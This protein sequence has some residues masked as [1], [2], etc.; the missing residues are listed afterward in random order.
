VP[1]P[2]AKKPS[3]EHPR[4]PGV[5]RGSAARRAEPV[6]DMATP[7]GIAAGSNVPRSDDTRLNIADLVQRYHAELYRY[8]YRLSGSQADAEDLTQQV[9]L[10]AQVRGHQLRDE[11]H[12]R[13]WLFTI[14]RNTYLKMVR[15][16]SP[17]SAASLDLDLNGVPA[18]MAE[19]PVDRERLQAA[20]DNLPP[21]FKIPVLMFYFE[22]CSYHEIAQQLGVPDGTVMSRLSRAKAYLR[23]KLS[24]PSSRNE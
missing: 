8:A 10:T 16:P 3:R 24:V 6:R 22:G 9:F 17:V 14:L 11:R 4:G 5:G 20:L 21:E 18:A 12:V 7:E 1:K 2:A 19:T 23:R 13:S 15:R